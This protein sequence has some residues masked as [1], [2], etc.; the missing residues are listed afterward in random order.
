MTQSVRQ[1]YWSTTGGDLVV[2]GLWGLP[3][4]HISGY[5][6]ASLQRLGA[7]AWIFWVE[8]G[9]VPGMQERQP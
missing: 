9:T 7:D 1:S 4:T 3:L 8:L 5:S 2:R 6:V